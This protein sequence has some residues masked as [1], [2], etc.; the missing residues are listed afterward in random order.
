MRY[1]WALA[2][3]LLLAAPAFAQS[4]TIESLEQEVRD[5]L[6]NR[7][8]IS[9]NIQKSRDAIQEADTYIKK[10]ERELADLPPLVA[11]LR[12]GTEVEP[13][14]RAK[15]SAENTLAFSETQLEQ[16]TADL[17]NAERKLD[18]LVAEQ[19]RK[20]EQAAL[21]AR[22]A[23]EKAARLEAER[24]AEAKRI[25]DEQ[26][27]AA[28]KAAAE[29]AAEERRIARE[30]AR[31]KRQWTLIAVVGGMLVA[32]FGLFAGLRAM[33]VSASIAEWS[34]S[35]YWLTRAAIVLTFA[36]F[37]L[38]TIETVFGALTI[39]DWMRRPLADLL[40]KASDAIDPEAQGASQ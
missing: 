14:E 20:E 7:E 39:P 11:A 10:K 13:F 40:D 29:Q 1:W 28:E 26:R 18:L 15:K 27:I 35:F 5:L 24:I 3:C 33:G 2:L 19:R 30:E 9:R 23:A 36:L 34:R 16:N 21:E 32:L 12:K 31:A 38:A 6:E 17:R 22:L 4:L 37:F 8:I 25:A